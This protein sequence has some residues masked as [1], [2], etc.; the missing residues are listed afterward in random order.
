MIQADRH[1]PKPTSKPKNGI[2]S[3]LAHPA[4]LLRFLGPGLVTSA[5]DDD[6]SGL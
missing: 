6:P 5:A 1:F 4:R 3:I 2:R